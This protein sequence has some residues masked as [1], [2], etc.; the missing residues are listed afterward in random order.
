MSKVLLWQTFDTS[1]AH[2]PPVVF[3]QVV[4]V[5]SS[6]PQRENKDTT[7]SKGMKVTDSPV[8]CGFRPIRD[9]NVEMVGEG[10]L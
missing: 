5:S 7:R 2:T 9:Q 6:R 1:S 3:N 4:R 8:G 10:G